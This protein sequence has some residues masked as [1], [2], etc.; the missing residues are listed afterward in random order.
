MLKDKL[1]SIV[2][3]SIYISW[4]SYAILVALCVY[5]YVIQVNEKTLMINLEKQLMSTIAANDA[6]KYRLVKA[7]KEIAARD[8]HIE[9]ALDKLE[10]AVK[11]RDTLEGKIKEMT[12]QS[13]SVD[14]AKTAKV[15]HRVK[16]LTQKNIDKIIKG[17]TT[18][19]EIVYI[20]GNPYSKISA[21]A[22]E[23][24]TYMDSNQETT[25]QVY[26]K[27]TNLTVIFDNRGVVREFN[28]TK[29]EQLQ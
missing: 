13:S 21:P 4:L 7:D 1:L 27:T 26:L 10:L 16:T 15:I 22:G 20:F 18:K 19:A 5:L 28:S 11:E 17:S 12:G 2:K 25:G 9:L 24:W 6:L 8:E 23:F 29:M 14:L 3:P